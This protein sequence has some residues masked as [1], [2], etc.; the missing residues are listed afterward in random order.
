MKKI[1][2]KIKNNIF[3]CDLI[4]VN[5]NILINFILCLINIRFRLWFIVFIVLISL[6]GFIIGTFQ[7]VHNATDNMKSVLI[8][9]LL[10]FF[11]LILLFVVVTSII[12]FIIFFRSQPEHTV[13]LDSKKYVAVVNSFIN[14]DVD[15]YDYYGPILMGTKI[16]VH[17]YFGKGGF[18]PFNN[19]NIVDSVE[20]TFYDNNGK[21]KS[22]RNENFIKDKDGNIVDS[23]SYYIDTSHKFNENDYYLLPENEEVLYEKKFNKTILRFGKV[24]NVLGQ[25]MLVN[26]LK[27]TDNGDSFYFVSDE[28]IQVSTQAKFVFLTEN[29]GFVISTGKIYLDNNKTGLYVTNDSGKTFVSANFKYEDKGVE[30]IDIEEVPYYEK[31]ILKIK[32]SVYQFNSN[33]DSYEDKELIFISTDNGLNWFSE[34]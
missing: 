9:V 27:S 20:Y 6:I 3:L 16:R 2:C 12:G 10:G 11:N 26:V 4:F 17:G 23:N 13:T 18:D 21:I 5:I 34:S 33:K 25:N 31:D 30:Y 24:D 8:K 1:F 28:V 15:Y 29:L 7:E 22:K 14:V 32:C 19:P